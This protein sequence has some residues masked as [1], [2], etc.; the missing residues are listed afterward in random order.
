MRRV[1]RW[2]ARGLA[3]L[4]LLIV[5]ILV[6]GWFWLRSGLPTDGTEIVT[7]AVDAPVRIWRDPHGVPHIFA[8]T[9]ED[10]AFAIGWLH[11]EDRLWQMDAAR[12]LVDGRLAALIGPAGLANDK[13]M[14]LLRLSER[15]EADVAVLS[16]ELRR[17][18]ER[19]AAGVNAWIAWD[20]APLPPEH[21]L[22]GLRPAPWDV[23]D[24]LG[25]AYLMALQLA[26]DFRDELRAARVEAVLGPT[27]AAPLLSSALSDGP[28]SIAAS[29]SF[30]DRL[31][32][33]LPDPLGPDTAS[34]EWAVAAFRSATG[35]PIL[36]NDP[37]LGL[38]A[39]ILWYL[40]RIVTPDRSWA[41]ATAPGNPLLLLGQNDDL[42]WGFTTAVADTQDLFLLDLDPADP[43]RWLGPDG[44]EAFESWTETIEIAGQA[45]ETV[46]FRSTRYG[47]VVSDLDPALAAEAL[48]EG[49][50]AALGFAAIAAPNTTGEALYRMNLATGW[51]SFHAALQHWTA[52]I[53]NVAVA[54]RE[55]TIAL[56]MP[57]LIPV[58]AE[59]HA[60]DRPVTPGQA[61]LAWRGFIPFS[62]LP[63]QIDPESG[64]L[65]NAN[66]PTVGPPYPH[67]LGRTD[68]PPYRALRIGEL[69]AAEEALTV[70]G[71]EVMLADTL[72]LDVPAVVSLLD[73]VSPDT[74]VEA[75]ALDRLRHWDGR[76]LRER[77]EP[78]I[79]MTFLHRLN[80]AL[81]ADELGDL[82]E[83]FRRPLPPRLLRLA[84]E[85]P[86]WCDDVTTAAEEIC[87]QITA[88]AFR[89]T[90][91]VLSDAYGRDPATW[92]WGDAHRAPL[93][94]PVWNRIPLLGDL[95]WPAVETD[96]GPFTVNRGDGGRGTMDLLF[97]H[98]HGA[99][100]RAVYDLAD[101]AASRFVIA[102]GQSGNPLSPH[103]RDL[104]ALWRDG[105]H[106]TL[107]GDEAMLA[108]RG[109]TGMTI[110]PAA[111]AGR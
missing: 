27:R 5:A 22:L 102:T 108:G 24:S 54:T 17:L 46:T 111:A 32:A 3:A 79:Y 101:P 52:P 12:R 90:V 20:G 86:G 58:R 98:T 33:A 39:P 80:A 15:A 71:A 62:A 107:F 89:E 100:Y 93:A 59:G 65:W 85:A 109:G 55:G 13:F 43:D 82:F 51:E 66:N 72:S 19:Y 48:A 30:L 38:S 49:Q 75:Q 96:G 4:L 14:R 95:L 6:A 18:L 60:G 37:H 50:V 77:P 99:G 8:D 97:P 34:N 25:W 53:Q 16:P 103:Y 57:G 104:V 106:L 29:P 21:L 68:E 28:Y 9:L 63:V 70:E 11:A 36:A 35:A 1:W 105:G 81:L 67:T 10:A 83:A 76:M 84:A 26:G 44:P 41:G 92:R 73:G 47:P 69:L 78:L 23:A 56:A 40:V 64:M 110:R 45:A 94:H 7:D 42:A 91:A 87:P 61:D 88:R 74:L 2:L 31:H